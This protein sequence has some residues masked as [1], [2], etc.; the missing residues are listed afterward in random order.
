[1]KILKALTLFCMIHTVAG[2]LALP[3][4]NAETQEELKKKAD[5]ESEKK[6]ALIVNTILTSVTKSGCEI[7]NVEYDMNSKN[8]FGI[9]SMD[10]GCQLLFDSH[11]RYNLNTGEVEKFVDNVTKDKKSKDSDKEKF[12]SHL[13]LRTKG[14]LVD[15]KIVKSADKGQFSLHF[16]GGIDRAA[17]KLV[18]VPLTAIFSNRL[19]RSL[20]T[21][22]LVSIDINTKEDPTNPNVLHID[23]NCESTQAIYNFLTGKPEMKASPCYVKGTYDFELGP[24][25][26][27]GYNELPAP[28]QALP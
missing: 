25:L 22:N 9:T 13:I 15:M 26:K 20:I 14:L 11:L 10:F 12:L 24:K 17:Q 7:K 1:M 23:G 2:L 27:A 28:Q 19:N 21:L 6:I 3:S 5:R 4:A 8:L 16:F 18:G